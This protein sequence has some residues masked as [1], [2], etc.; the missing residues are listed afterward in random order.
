MRATVRQA[1]PHRA[2]TELL[3]PDAERALQQRGGVG[4]AAGLQYDRL[5]GH[6]PRRLD[7][8]GPD[9]RR[10]RC[11]ERGVLLGRLRATRTVTDLVGREDAGEEAFAVSLDQIVDPQALDDVR[12]DADRATR[13]RFADH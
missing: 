1:D 12:P 2:D 4:R 11:P 7:L 10:L 6:A 5:P 3:G 13:F 8:E 9:G